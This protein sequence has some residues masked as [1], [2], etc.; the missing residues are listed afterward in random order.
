MSAAENQPA[1]A[2]PESRAAAPQ[3]K[4]PVPPDAPPA[5][6]ANLALGAGLLLS[7]F[8]IFW[9]A[10][11]L[12]NRVALRT[13]VASFGTFALVWVLWRTRVF[14]RRHGGMIAAGA[15]ALFAA[16]LPFVE[17]GFVSLD[18]AAK[19]G[20]A[21][22][23]A[24]AGGDLPPSA[25]A[26]IPA[27]PRQTLPVPPA[28][29]T[30]PPAE[31][32]TV[33]DLVATEPDASVGKIILVKQDAK[34]TINGKKFLIKAGSKFP[35]KKLEDGIVTFSANGQDATIESS[36]V[37]FTGHSKETPEEITKLAQV[38]LV[39]RYP[40]VGVK[41]SPENELFVSRVQELK[42]EL[43]EIFKNP[44]WPLEIGEQV[45]A[46]EG[47]KRADIPEDETPPAPPQAPGAKVIPAPDQAAPPPPPEPE[48]P[49]A[50][51]PP[52]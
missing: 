40:A 1:P 26:I 36:M 39:R 25:P 4:T 2:K 48:A 17:R 28:P 11:Y 10:Q 24:A 21:G 5:D 33:H 14:Q 22:E 51:P 30:P 50:L 41:D 29:V 27:P 42:T 46:K 6:L 38:E 8:V 52:R 16:V 31:D 44:R 34:L 35:F 32:D 9:I 12:P 45:A 23:P 19:A 15:V 20:L 7:A 49:P 13:L 37:S 3:A 43:P 47:W 18:R